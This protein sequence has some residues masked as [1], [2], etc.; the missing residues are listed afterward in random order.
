MLVPRFVII[1]FALN[2]R[3]YSNIVILKFLKKHIFPAIYY[4]IEKNKNKKIKYH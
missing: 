2:L 4:F 1:Y 3:K